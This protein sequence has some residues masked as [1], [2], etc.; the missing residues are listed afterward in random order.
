MSYPNRSPLAAARG[1]RRSPPHAS[2]YYGY[3]YDPSRPSILSIAHD[4]EDGG[5]LFVITDR[6][7]AIVGDP[8]ALPLVVPVESP[9]AIVAVEEVLPVKFRVRLGGA[10]PQGA[11][12]HWSAGPS[13]LVDVATG[14]SPNPAA[15]DCADFPGP[16]VPPPVALTLVSAT[17]DSD[18]ELL[19]LTFDR[20]VDVSLFNGA[21]IYVGDGLY[22]LSTYAGLAATLDAPT[23]VRITLNPTGEYH[24]TDVRMDGS[25]ASGI[26]ATDD[27]GAWPGT[28]GTITL[29][30]FT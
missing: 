2:P 21:A 4:E 27:G 20:A 11:A 8:L 25:P 28:G 7:C 9:L 1:P 24:D 5:S 12:W 30:Y 16:Y 29:P 26:V 14:R 22:H 18:F 13:A 23:I 19:F 3:G 15:G 17:F 6:P 10:V